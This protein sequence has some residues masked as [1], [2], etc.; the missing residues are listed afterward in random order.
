MGGVH[1]DTMRRLRGYSDRKYGTLVGLQDPGKLKWSEYAGYQDSQS[2][3][4][5][6][7]ALNVER[8]WFD[9]GNVAPTGNKTAPRAWGALA[10]A[11]LG[12][13]AA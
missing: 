5:Q 10:C 6:I 8:E 1:I 7:A 13:P 2:I 12:I 3:A 9:S 11:Y 4:G